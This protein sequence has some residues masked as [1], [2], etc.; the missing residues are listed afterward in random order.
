MLLGESQQFKQKYLLMNNM[1][2]GHTKTYSPKE[3]EEMDINILDKIAFGYNDGDVIT[4]DAGKVVIKY[5]GDLENA[6]EC[7]RRGGMS[8]ARSV[9]LDDPV[10]VSIGEDG[11]MYLEDG[12][13]RRFAAIKRGAKLSAE[14][15]I[16]G[17]PIRFILARQRAE[18]AKQKGQDEG[19]S[20]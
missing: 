13:H 14:V 12:H 4:I 17:N 18:L 10:Q 9:C 1:N 3:L 20:L 6:E 7:F 15:E 2:S 16:K 5:P 19:P 11:K 8:W